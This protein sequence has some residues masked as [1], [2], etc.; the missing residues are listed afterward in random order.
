VTVLRYMYDSGTEIA[1]VKMDKLCVGFLNCYVGSAAVSS[2]IAALA[3]KG[4]DWVLAVD[5]DKWFVDEGK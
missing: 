1:L 4:D 5:E 2:A 3:K